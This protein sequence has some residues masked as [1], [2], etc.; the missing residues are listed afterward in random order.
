MV[1]NPD[2]KNFN[3]A[4]QDKPHRVFSKNDYYKQRQIDLDYY[5]HLLNKT[6]LQCWE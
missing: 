2:A 6:I 5:T 4:F 1:Y 3:E